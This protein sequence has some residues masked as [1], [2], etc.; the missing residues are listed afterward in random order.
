VGSQSRRCRGSWARVGVPAPDDLTAAKPTSGPLQ[1]ALSLQP[2]QGSRARPPLI[3]LRGAGDVI[4]AFGGDQP[5]RATVRRLGSF[6]RVGRQ[7]A[8]ENTLAAASDCPH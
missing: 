5:R 2:E 6:L 4:V 8:D 1:P 7:Y 3:V